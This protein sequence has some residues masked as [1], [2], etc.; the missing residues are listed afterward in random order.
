MTHRLSRRERK[1]LASVGQREKKPMVSVDAGG[2]MAGIKYAISN[3]IAVAVFL[4]WLMFQNFKEWREERRRH[5][6]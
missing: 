6:E 5:E 3:L 1:A 4:P 2:I